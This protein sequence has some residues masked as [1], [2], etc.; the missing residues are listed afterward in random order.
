MNVPL[1]DHRVQYSPFTQSSLTSRPTT[2]S[3]A[4]ALSS[5]QH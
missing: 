5:R 4:S 3:T 2:S 1:L